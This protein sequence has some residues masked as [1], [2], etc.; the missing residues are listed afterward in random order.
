MLDAETGSNVLVNQGWAALW[1]GE[2]LESSRKLELA[3]R[4]FKRSEAKWKSSSPIKAQL[5]CIRS[6]KVLTELLKTGDFQ[7]PS[8]AEI[9]R[10]CKE[11]LKYGND[12]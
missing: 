7:L 4:F 11:W 3:Y 6:D 1:L 5:S 2:L 8:D 12:L 9:E 10:Q